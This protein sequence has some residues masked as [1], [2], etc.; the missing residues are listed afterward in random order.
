MKNRYSNKYSRY[1][2]SSADHNMVISIM[3]TCRTSGCNASIM[4]MGKPNT[5]A[6][7]VCSTCK[8]E[9]VIVIPTPYK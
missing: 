6:S 5:E 8:V 3:S 7:S 2:Y 1:N 4:L 9:Q